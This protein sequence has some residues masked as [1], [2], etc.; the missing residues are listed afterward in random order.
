MP[1]QCNHCRTNHPN[2]ATRAAF[3]ITALMRATSG[4]TAADA[5]RALGVLP[6]PVV[7]G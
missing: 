4:L 5:E 2:R 3:A 7:G 6:G 1:V